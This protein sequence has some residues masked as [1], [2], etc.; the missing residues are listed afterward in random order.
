MAAGA[1]E[2]ARI[3]QFDG[4]SD[5]GGVQ[6]PGAASFDPGRQEYLVQASGTNMWGD[7]DE[8]HLVWKK[9][10]GDFIIQAMVAFEGQGAEAHRKAGIIVRSS[11]DPRSPHINACRHGNGLTALQFRRSPGAATE[12]DYFYLK[13]PNVLQLE[14]RG[15]SYIMSAARFGDT[16][17]SKQIS[18]VDLGDEVYVGIYVCSHN[19]G[20][21]EK[22]VF[23]NV[24]IT[25]P[26]P[27][28][29]VPYRDYLGSDLELLDTV[30]GARKVIYHTDD[31]LQ[32]PNWTPDGKALVFNRN[33]LM[34]HFDLASREPVRIDTGSATRC[35]NDHALSL[36][37]SMLGIS[38]SSPEDGNVS[39]VYTLPI[40]GG[41]PTKITMRGPSYLHGWSPDGKYLAFTG[42]RNGDYNIYRIPAKGG[43][44]ERLTTTKALLDDGSEYTPDGTTIYFNSNRTGRMQVWRMQADGTRQEQVTF[45]DFNNWFP[46]VSP[47]GRSVVFLSYDSSEVG[48]GEHP[49]YK[50]VYLRQIPIAGD[51]EPQVIAYLYGGQGT[52]NVNS[53]SPDNQTIAFVSN[54][55]RL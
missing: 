49:F 10:K 13:A 47:N 31:S 55:D 11:L 2:P 3:G 42:G 45:D 14:R 21:V 37:G 27:A 40:G 5:I 15:R 16:F 41:R 26:A 48:P 19:N 30:S 32:A 53:W 46:H 20:V 36:D 1:A 9:L 54:S 22:A 44:E 25:R 35:N 18:D 12:E 28:G 52:I 24:R 43:D 34:Y 7:H 51:E 38:S 6:F 4:Q 8:F 17:T 50:R 39:M 33:G 23:S 29:L